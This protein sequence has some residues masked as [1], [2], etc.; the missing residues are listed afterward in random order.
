[1]ALVF[2]LHQLRWLVWPAYSDVPARHT[3]PVAC[4]GQS[5][6]FIY[7]QPKNGFHSYHCACTFQSWHFTIGL[8]SYENFY[9]RSNA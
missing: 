4:L 8:A 6:L 7:N 9:R 5:E 1:M 2:S 3:Q